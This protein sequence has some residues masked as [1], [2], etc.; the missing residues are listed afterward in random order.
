MA[1]LRS[2][3]NELSAAEKADLL[4]AVW[5]SLEADSLLLTDLQRAELDRRIESHQRNP[6]D[7][8]PWEEVR[9]GLLKKL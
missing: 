6:S 3:I 9:A 5:E 4:D 1:D 8:V 2:Q 7:V